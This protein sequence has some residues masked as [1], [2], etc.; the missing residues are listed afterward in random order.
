MW[1]DLLFEFGDAWGTRGRPEEAIEAWKAALALY[2]ENPASYWRFGDADWAFG[3]SLGRAAGACEK[4]AKHTEDPAER[5]VWLERAGAWKE[6]RVERSRRI[7]EWA[8]AQR[9]VLADPA[10]EHRSPAR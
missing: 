8:E 10:G 2:P 7:T 1:S 4:I 6:R 9:R 3:L 5:E